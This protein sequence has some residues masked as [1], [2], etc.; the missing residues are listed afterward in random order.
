M[1]KALR[2]QPL[3]E[4]RRIGKLWAALPDDEKSKYQLKC[5]KEYARQRDALKAKGLTCCCD[6]N[7]AV[8]AKDRQRPSHMQCEELHNHKDKP[9]VF[10]NLTP[11]P[12]PDN[13]QQG[14]LLGEG[15]YGAVMLCTS[16]D[17]RRAA[18]NVFKGKTALIDIEHEASIMKLCATAPEPHWF[19]KLLAECVEAKPCPFL[20]LEWWGCSLLSHLE[21]HGAQDL[22]TVKAISLQLQA[23]LCQLHR[24][25]L[26]HL[27]LKPGNIL[28]L[29]EASH[30]KL[31]DFG[32]S[33]FFGRSPKKQGEELQQSQP[34]F[35][36]YVTHF[37][38]PP[39]LWNAT[40]ADV[41]RN[42]RPAVDLWSYWVRCVRMWTS[43]PFDGSHPS[44]RFDQ[45]VNSNL[46]PLLGKHAPKW[47][48]IT[49]EEPCPK[50]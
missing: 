31:A 22:K 30:L 21:K 43:T 3:R 50:P 34:R 10:G 11:M 33:E 12:D 9:G 49:P 17:G 20:A 6:C 18:I 37:Y 26:V 47:R 44:A 28:W 46:V 32:M 15:S 7:G 16:S 23:A 27:D 36:E 42:L 13:P 39:E 25:H 24:L 40:S 45:A 4:M 5:H 41:Q 48:P 29:S 14:L 1:L 2:A 19:P 35:S 38:R 8:P